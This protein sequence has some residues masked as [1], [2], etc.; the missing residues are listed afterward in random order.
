MISPDDARAR[1]HEM[2]DQI[3]DEQIGM[4]WMT[5]QSMMSTT[6]DTEYDDLEDAEDYEDDLDT[7]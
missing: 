1:I 6:D 7:I 5:F 4:L 2:I 3:P